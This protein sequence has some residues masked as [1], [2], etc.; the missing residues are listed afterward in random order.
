[1]PRA[2]GTAILN[3]RKDDYALIPVP[4]G[5]A[6]FTAFKGFITG[7]SWLHRDLAKECH[8]ITPTGRAATGTTR[9]DTAA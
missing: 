2:T 3:L 8:P 6:E 7:Q 9:K 5:P 4:A 1:M